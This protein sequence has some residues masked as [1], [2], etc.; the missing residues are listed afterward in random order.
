MGCC[1]PAGMLSTGRLEPL[2]GVW[3]GGIYARIQL[4]VALLDLPSGMTL[5]GTRTKVFLRTVKYFLDLCVMYPV[6]GTLVGLPHMP[7][8]N[9]SGYDVDNL[10]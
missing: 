6:Y 1:R 9:T 7:D 2:A 8:Y 5:R 10:R 4:A 3:P